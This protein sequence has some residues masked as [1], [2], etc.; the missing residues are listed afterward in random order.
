V[1]SFL[2]PACMRKVPL[3]QQL[4]EGLEDQTLL[5]KPQVSIVDKIVDFDSHAIFYRSITWVRHH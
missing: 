5:S 1:A 4:K 2:G 3:T